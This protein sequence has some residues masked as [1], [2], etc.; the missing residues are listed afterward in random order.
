MIWFTHVLSS[1]TSTLPTVAL[2]C[3]LLGAWPILL[4]ILAGTQ[5][6]WPQLISTA[7]PVSNSV[8]ASSWFPGGPVDSTWHRRAHGPT[9]L[10]WEICSV[11]E[12]TN[13]SYYRFYSSIHHLKSKA[14]WW[15]CPEMM[16]T[17]IDLKYVQL[18]LGLWNPK[19]PIFPTPIP[20][21][22]QERPRIGSTPC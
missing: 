12:K 10:P 15:A 7:D 6:I 8:Q 14:K 21:L 18:G 4:E 11:W 20:G 3:V 22:V 5:D 16:V 17:Q 9:H 2:A 19:A 13:R 1:L